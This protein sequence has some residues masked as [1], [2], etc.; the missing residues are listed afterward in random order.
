MSKIIDL[1]QNSFFKEK[2]YYIGYYYTEDK[3]CLIAYPHSMLNN[4]KLGAF[5]CFDDYLSL[6]EFFDYFSKETNKKIK[7]YNNV[8]NLSHNVIKNS[9]ISFFEEIHGKEGEEIHDLI[10]SVSKSWSI[11]Y[12]K[13]VH[14]YYHTTKR[15]TKDSLNDNWRKIKGLNY[16]Y[17]ICRKYDWDK[18]PNNNERI[19]IGI[20]NDL[21]KRLYDYNTH[22]VEE[23]EVIRVYPIIDPYNC[24][25]E[26]IERDIKNDC[27]YLKIQ[28][29]LFYARRSYI[30]TIVEKIIYESEKAKYR[31]TQYTEKY[32]KDFLLNIQYR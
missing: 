13:K 9:D 3:S 24:I 25:A 18:R 21:N 8:S 30:A 16:I 5:L 26:K 29:E 31:V 20:T 10:L 6:T 32:V 23:V 4:K 27:R 1:K 7:F 14:T 15:K 17:I 11:K 2:P 12:K 22:S 19:K 28:Q